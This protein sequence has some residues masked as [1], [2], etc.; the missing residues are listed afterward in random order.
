MVRVTPPPNPSMVN[1]KH[2]LNVHPVFDERI[3]DRGEALLA[4][5]M[6]GGPPF[7]YRV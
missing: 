4:G 2:I 7:T 3:H 6:H 1:Y 5:D